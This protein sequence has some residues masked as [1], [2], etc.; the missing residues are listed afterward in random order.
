MKQVEW[1]YHKTRISFTKELISQL[2]K[3]TIEMIFNEHSSW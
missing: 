2:P 1:D 3:L